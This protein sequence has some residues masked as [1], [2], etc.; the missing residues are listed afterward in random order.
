VPSNSLFINSFAISQ[1]VGV[2]AIRSLNIKNVVRSLKAGMGVGDYGPTCLY[3][4]HT[5]AKNQSPAIPL[6]RNNPWSCCKCNLHL[7]PLFLL[8]R[9]CDGYNPIS[10]LLTPGY[11][12]PLGG[13]LDARIDTSYYEYCRCQPF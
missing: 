9:D 3:S 2:P 6:Y 1:L 5:I 10:I 8:L 13:Y 12:I 11:N 7:Y 4:S